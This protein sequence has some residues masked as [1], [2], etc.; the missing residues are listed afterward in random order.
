VRPIL[1][2]RGLLTDGVKQNEPVRSAFL[3]SFGDVSA[4]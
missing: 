3:P 4:S 1:E 2:G